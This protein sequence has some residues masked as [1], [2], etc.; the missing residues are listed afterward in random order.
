MRSQLC[1][2]AAGVVIFETKE[3]DLKRR[4]SIVCTLGITL[5]LLLG[6]VN[7]AFGATNSCINTES[8]GGATLALMTH[9]SLSLAVLGFDANVNGGFGYNNEE[10]GFT[11]SGATNGTQDFTLARSGSSPGQY[12]NGNFVLEFTPG[13]L[14]PPAGDLAY[15]LSLQDTYPKVNGTVVQRWAAVL[16]WCGAWGGVIN[17]GV[18]SPES[19]TTISDAD[20]YQLWAPVE[21]AGNYLQLENVALNDPH[22]THGFPSGDFVLDDR[23]NG[24][25]NTWALAFPN[26]FGLNQEGIATGCTKPITTFNP[27]DFN[28]PSSS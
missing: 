16:R 15:C 23:A 19:E 5:T 9:G 2:A 1:V 20:T 27:H 10:V 25:N 8:C 26:H 12:G 3:K 7:A 14:Q 22:L 28:C 13:G 18:K 11:T 4:N 21:V 24:G 17:P 6:V